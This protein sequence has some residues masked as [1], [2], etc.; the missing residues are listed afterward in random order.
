M[1]ETLP[2]VEA[3]EPLAQAV[4]LARFTVA[5]VA[6][7]AE[8]GLLRD[9][10]RYEL[11]NGLLHAMHAPGPNHQQL[12]RNLVYFL[13]DR[14]RE[15]GMDPRH[16]V[17]QGEALHFSEATYRLPDLMVLSAPPV[18]GGAPRLVRPHDVELVVEVSV[19]TYRT[20]V[21]DKLR[22]YA[23]GGI[24][25]Y[26]VVRVDAA[27]WT[28][29]VLEVRRGPVDEDYAEV[30]SLGYGD[31]PLTPAGPSLRRLGPLRIEDVLG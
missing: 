11:L 29:R 22:R 16:R 31:G 30:A 7:M 1:A 28:D 21:G 17:L 18:E 8:A 13:E 25:E 15:A 26:W 4:R 12:V 3:H 10:R 2:T 24:P 9:D 19:S 23:R 6:R 20:D 14:M 5:D 27:D